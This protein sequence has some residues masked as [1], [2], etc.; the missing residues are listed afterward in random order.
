MSE[1]V[2]A[3]ET[4]RAEAD[5]FYVGYLPVPARQARY[6]RWTAG[7][8]AAIAAGVAATV[9][10]SIRSPGTGVWDTDQ[11]VELV[12][13]IRAKPY[14]CLEVA[15]AAIA[16]GVRC[17]LL[18]Q[19]GKHGAGPDAL[20]LD[21][22]LVRVRGYPLMRSDQRLLELLASPTPVDGRPPAEPTTS[23]V[24]PVTLRGEII[25]PKCYFGAMKPGAGKTHKACATLCIAGG[26]PPM[27]VTRAVDGGETFY[28]LS[29]GADGPVTE[30]VL[31]Y[32]A[33]PV[34]IVATTC[35]R[36]G[37]RLLR[38]APGAISRL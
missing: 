8:L 29:D 27:F 1:E 4:R 35:E 23:A 12:G 7:L 30:L 24:R 16:G 6:L 5:E 13:R 31:P 25:D 17:I 26:I 3:S 21:G 11:P 37:L 14:A 19:Q 10:F 18:V 28:L 20:P 32:V 2:S 22:R 15:D 33:D 36:G 9:A 34:E 38:I